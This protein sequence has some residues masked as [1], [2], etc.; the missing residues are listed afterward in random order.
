MKT[1]FPKKYPWTSVTSDPA[2][3]PLSFTSELPLPP[4]KIQ[5]PPSLPSWILFLRRVGLLSVLIHTPAMALSKISLSSMKPKPEKK[6]QKKSHL[7]IGAA[8]DRSNEDRHIKQLFWA[9]ATETSDS[10]SGVK[11]QIEVPFGEQKAMDSVKINKR[12]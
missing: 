5:M 4:L 6:N 7:I 1:T 11:K 8:R 12:R 2:Q 3:P 10:W 9:K